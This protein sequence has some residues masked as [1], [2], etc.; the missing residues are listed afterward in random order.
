MRKFTI[1]IFLFLFIGGKEAS[2]EV[3]GGGQ[4]SQ[5]DNEVQEQVNLTDLEQQMREDFRL[6][7][8]ELYNERDRSRKEAESIIKGMMEVLGDMKT[9]I[10]ESREEV[11]DMNYSKGKN[12]LIASV[13]LWISITIFIIMNLIFANS[14]KKEL[15]F[16]RNGLLRSEIK[17]N[18]I[19]LSKQLSDL[20]EKLEL[21]NKK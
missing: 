3:F 10:S 5:R 11:R 7:L 2:A 21:I 16:L 20:N 15:Y 12:L 8:Q 4:V 14:L 18:M 6:F 19:N 17:D 9:L 13:F 1:F